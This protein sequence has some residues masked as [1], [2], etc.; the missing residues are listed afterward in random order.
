[1][2]IDT[3]LDFDLYLYN[4]IS[5][6]YIL[7][8]SKN[9]VFGEK[10]RSKL[11]E[12]KVST[13]YLTADDVPLYNRYLEKNLDRII[14]NPKIRE[15]EKAH[16]VYQSARN[17]MEET[18]SKSDSGENIQRS[19]RFVKNTVHFILKEKNSFH[20]II[21]LTSHDYY[22][23]THSINVCIYAVSLARR[24]GIHDTQTLNTI[25]T[26][27][28]LH[29]IGKST[30][31]LEVLT[32]KGPLDKEEWLTMK[33]HPQRGV[34]LLS[35]HR[36]IP[37]ILEM[38]RFHH[39]KL[40]GSGYPGGLRDREIPRFA[41]IVCISDIFDALNTKRPYKNAEDTFHSL[42]IMLKEFE[43][44]IDPLLLK[45]FIMMFNKK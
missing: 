20:N 41:R 17:L 2:L 36:F 40:D 1:V 35:K 15:Q 33:E 34:E 18:F 30:I 29:D 5:R 32:K 25:G 16:I 43:N 19:K 9:T 44:K 14:D 42:N 23:Y 12:N 37:E 21:N 39:E 6:N 10:N 38:V 4:K 28:L 7:Y 22:T 8:R 27:A 31:P 24:A 45:E 13:L 11:F 26:G 3:I